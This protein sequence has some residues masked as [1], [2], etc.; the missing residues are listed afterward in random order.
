MVGEKTPVSWRCYD[1]ELLF[2]MT[3]NERLIYFAMTFAGSCCTAGPAVPGGRDQG[4]TN[5][6]AW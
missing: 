5:R 4:D 6:F 1:N 3:T 2:W